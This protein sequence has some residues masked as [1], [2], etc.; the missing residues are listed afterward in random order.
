MSQRSHHPKKELGQN[1]LIDTR[2]QQKIIEACELDREDVVVEIGPGQGV[3]TKL[4]TPRVKKLICVETDRDLIQPLR[5]NLPSCVEIIHADFL[6]W[7]MSPLA[8]GIKVI[9]NIPYYISTPIIEKLIEHK[10]K[11]ATAFLTVQLEFGERLAARAGGKDYGSLS[12]F[13]QYSSDIKML[14]KIKNTCFRPVPQVNSCFMRL[15][16]RPWPQTPAR[17]DEFLFKFIQ[18]A[19]QQRRKTIVNALK[20]LV[21]REQLEDVLKILG[22]PLNARPENLTLSNYI[23][24]CNG[25]ML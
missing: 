14:F 5:I 8:D 1:F 13:A 3:L 11:I 21:D 19:F 2:I 10:T 25:I 17:D 20:G 22:I 16:M 18:T 4:M 23:N 7:D 24:L 6:K 15:M 12:C 9:G